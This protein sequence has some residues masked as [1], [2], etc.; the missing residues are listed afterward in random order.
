MFNMIL[1]KMTPL[2]GEVGGVVQEV[3]NSKEDEWACED[4]DVFLER[5]GGG[6]KITWIWVMRKLSFL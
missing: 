4:E 2:T 5:E 6:S 1:M 3:S